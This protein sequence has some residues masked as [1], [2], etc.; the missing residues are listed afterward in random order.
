ME[1]ET[2][3]EAEIMV[4]EIII[5]GTMEIIGIIE[6]IETVAEII[7]NVVMTVDRH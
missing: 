4:I 1:K 7:S 6:I 3:E 2:T 5:D